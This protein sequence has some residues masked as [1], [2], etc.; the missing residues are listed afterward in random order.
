MQKRNA[1][2]VET[3]S[4]AIS[5]FGCQL[6]VHFTSLRSFIFVVLHRS[7]RIVQDILRNG[8]GKNEMDEMYKVR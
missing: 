5:S 6:P 1:F 4:I 3:Y 2:S 8:K 7:A